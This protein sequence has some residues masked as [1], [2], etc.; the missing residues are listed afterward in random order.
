MRHISILFLLSLLAYTTAFAQSEPDHY[1]KISYFDAESG[2]LILQN[3]EQIKAKY[4]QR[5]DQEMIVSWRMYHVLFSSNATYRYRFVTVETVESLNDMETE[6]NLADGFASE[7]ES[8]QMPLMKVHSE[9]WGARGKVVGR[10]TEQPSRYKNANFMTVQPDRLDDYYD[11]ESQIAAPLHQYQADAG[12]MDG[13]NFY[14]LIFPTGSAVQYNFITADY[15]SRLEQIEF[16]F[17]PEVMA[18]IHPELD[19]EEFEEFADTIRE[20]VWSDLWELVLS[21]E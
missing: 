5:V 20:R 12:K 3:S 7:M 11:L 18:D 13:W 14:R 15:Y 10:G 4:Q 6:S 1:L 21:V 17:S 9:I 8:S 16:G 2:D 19:Q